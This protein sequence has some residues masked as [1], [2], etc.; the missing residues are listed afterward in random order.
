MNTH[1]HLLGLFPLTMVLL[2][3]EV[4]PLHIFED[5]YK[6]LINELLDG[7]EF[8][9]L[10][11][12]EEGIHEIGCSARVSEL[13]ERFDDG[14]MNILA[15]GA[16]RFRLLEIR[17]PDD[18]EAHYMV[19]VVEYFDDEDAAATP[20]IEVEALAQYAAIV[21]LVDP[22]LPREPSGEG[23]LSFRLAASFDFGTAIEQE[24]LESGSEQQR[25]EKLVAVMRALLPR[26][27]LRKEREGAIRG[28][29]KGY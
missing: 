7:G 27:Q 21:A 10:F 17:R 24:L 28:N 1:E 8:G 6:L 3:G 13:I 14:R 25:L 5:R 16:R 15:Q 9:V 4:M 26:L 20:E 23:L 11:V 19:G 29:G 18:M 2:P 12:E 22:A